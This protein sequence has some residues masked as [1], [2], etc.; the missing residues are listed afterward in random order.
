MDAGHHSLQGLDAEGHPDGIAAVVDERNDEW[1]GMRNE[2]GSC[3]IQAFIVGQSYSIVAQ[4]K[5]KHMRYAD[6][7]RVH[8]QTTNKCLPC[9]A[10]AEAWT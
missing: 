2:S 10:G 1:R 8:R 4:H 7:W 6:K 9:A 5:K 3:F